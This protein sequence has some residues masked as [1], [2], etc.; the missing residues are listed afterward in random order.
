MV[1][2]ILERPEQELIRIMK[3]N[4]EILVPLTDEMIRKLDRKKGIL[5]LNT[6]PGLIDLY[7]D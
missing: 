3:G 5:Y 1:D 7:L 4:K 6:P 2:E